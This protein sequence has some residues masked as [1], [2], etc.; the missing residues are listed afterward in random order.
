VTPADF[1]YGFAV[2]FAGMWIGLS[3]LL[4]RMSG[5]HELAE[6]Y[7]AAAEPAGERLI[8]NSAQ[9]G[10]VS[11]RSC[12]N[13]NLSSSGFYMSPSLM[14][15]LF[16]PPLLIPWSDVRFEGFK[17]FFFL[18]LSC[19]R[20]GG[21]DGPVLFLWR[22]TG[23]RFRPYLADQGRLDHAA[24]KPFSGSLIDRRIWILAAALGAAG[25]VVSLLLRKR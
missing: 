5:W 2:L 6:R 7:R 11:F 4:S 24:E 14:F 21:P 23:E 8:W 20:L 18:E 10:A 17:P 1:P 13:M 16:M 22:K 25:C 3:F 15:R 12:L 9:V 19:Y